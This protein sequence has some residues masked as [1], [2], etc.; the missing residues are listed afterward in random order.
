MK[1]TWRF[2]MKIIGLSLAAAGVICLIVGCWDKLAEEAACLRKKLTGK[3]GY[4]EFSDYDD[5][6]FYEE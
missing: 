1:S 4:S 6:L 5:D 3:G 2:V